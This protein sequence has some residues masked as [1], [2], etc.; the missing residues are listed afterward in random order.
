MGPILATRGAEKD[1]IPQPIQDLLDNQLCTQLLEQP[2]HV[3]LN[4]ALHACASDHPVN[5]NTS[6]L[7]S[8]ARGWNSSEGTQVGPMRPP[9]RR[10]RTKDYEQL[11]FQSS[12]SSPL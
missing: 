11:P 4:P 1:D 12:S 6:D 3:P 5:G 8:L 10:V 9:A 2:Q 7:N